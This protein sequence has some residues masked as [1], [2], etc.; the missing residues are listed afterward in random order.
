MLTLAVAAL[1]V[2][3]DLEHLPVST[4]DVARKTCCVCALWSCWR[5]QRSIRVV[6]HGRERTRSTSKKIERCKTKVVQ[7]ASS[8]CTTTVRV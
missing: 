2:V 1:V 6:V 3:V 5:Q 4:L 7:E 8:L